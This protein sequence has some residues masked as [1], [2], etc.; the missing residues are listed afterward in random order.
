MFIAVNDAPA[1]ATLNG[2]RRYTH[3]DHFQKVPGYVTFAPHRFQRL[4]SP[5]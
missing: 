4:S 1:R 3:G 2:V 5:V